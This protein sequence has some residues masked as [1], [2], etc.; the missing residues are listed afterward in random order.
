MPDNERDAILQDTQTS[1]DTGQLPLFDVQPDGT[2]VLPE[3]S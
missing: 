1:V 3:A 2:F